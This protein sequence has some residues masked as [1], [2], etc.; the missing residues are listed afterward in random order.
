MWHNHTSSQRNK[1]TERTV[2]VGVGGNR[3]GG[4]GQNLKKGV[5]NIGGLHKYRGE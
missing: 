4:I 3:K 1:K 5:G 2:G